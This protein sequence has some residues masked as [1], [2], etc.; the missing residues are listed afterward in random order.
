MKD[1][2]MTRFPNVF[3]AAATAALIAGAASAQTSAF[4]R[5]DSV[6]DAVTAIEDDIEEDFDREARVFG[7]QGRAIGMT[8]SVS[9]RATATNGNTE[10]ADVGVGARIGYFDGING[11]DITLAY[12]FSE[13]AGDVTKNSLLAGYDYTR[14]I[15]S[16]AYIFGKALYAYDEFG[17]YERDAFVGAGL[18]YRILN[19]EVQQWSVQAGPGY[20]M[21]TAA[22]GD[23]VEEVAV[24]ASSDYYY[25][26]TDTLFLTND[27]D[28]LWSETD[29]YV[30]NELGV[31]VAMTD[32]L[33]L[34][35]SLL[36]EYRTDPL[37]GFK[38]TDNT[39]GVSVVYTFN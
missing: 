3:V 32:Q 30:T 23:T 34:R 31:N 16:N 35:T 2:K 33:A 37:P 20:R 13:A 4:D 5:Q 36:T 11:N 22:N 12:T 7:N 24:S 14:E 1:Y 21:A 25:K 26:F 15:S 38:N 39:L 10:T 18:G 8:G 6:T 29:T 19:T 27:S 17:T 28:V 9:L